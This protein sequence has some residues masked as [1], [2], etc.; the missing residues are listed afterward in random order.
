MLPGVTHE[1]NL[2]SRLNYVISY[3][4]SITL[5]VNQADS[6]W[7]PYTDQEVLNKVQLISMKPTPQTKI[8]NSTKSDLPEY[9]QDLYDISSKHLDKDQC[10]Q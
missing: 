5:H 2:K 6:T 7:E 4:K 1:N 9:L 10:Q 3:K 8:V